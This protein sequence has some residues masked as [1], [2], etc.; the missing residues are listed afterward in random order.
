MKILAKIQRKWHNW[1]QYRKNIKFYEA[2]LREDTS[3]NNDTIIT[4]L[5]FKLARTAD[6]YNSS[7]MEYYNDWSKDKQDIERAYQLAKWIHGYNQDAFFMGTFDVNSGLDELCDI[8]KN[9]RK[10]WD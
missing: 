7:N 5:L 8:L 1:R 2:F 6:Y 4:F 9:H 10:W 3:Y